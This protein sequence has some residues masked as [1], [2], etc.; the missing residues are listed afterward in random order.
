VAN[1]AWDK[2][3]DIRAQAKALMDT[4]EADGNACAEALNDAAEKAPNKSF[5]ESFGEM[6]DDLGKWFKDHLGDIGDIAGIVSAVAG[7]LAFIPVLAPIAGPVALI[8]GGVALAAHAGDMTVNDKWG[9]PNAWIS[10]AGDVLGLIPGGKLVAEGFKAGGEAASGATKL[11]D[12]GRATIEGGKVIADGARAVPDA[13]KV[14]VWVADRA[15]GSGSVVADLTA[16][17]LQAG[18]NVVLQ[19][20]G[21]VGLFDNSGATTT[22]KNVAGGA[23]A[24]LNSIQWKSL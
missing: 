1:T 11:V 24:L 19:I 13:A 15:V 14:F 20:P 23:A 4:W 8:A 3:E 6:F 21:A 17:S 2:L 5:F 16:K 22:S 18:S 9:D 10:V 7:A 12:I